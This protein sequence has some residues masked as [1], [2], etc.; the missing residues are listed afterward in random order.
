MINLKVFPISVPTTEEALAIYGKKAKI[1]YQVS[2]ELQDPELTSE[3][4]EK[5]IALSQNLNKKAHQSPAEFINCS[6]YVQDASK[7]VLLL[8]TA[9]DLPYKGMVRSLRFREPGVTKYSGPDYDL[10]DK[11]HALFLDVI[12][13]EYPDMPD[14]DRQTAANQNSR[15]FVNLFSP[16]YSFEYCLDFR[17]LCYFINWLQDF[18]KEDTSGLFMHLAQIEAEQLAAQLKELCPAAD[19]IKDTKGG[20]LDLFKK[21]IPS[22]FYGRS[23][24]HNFKDV[25]WD[26]IAHIVRHRKDWRYWLVFDEL[27][28]SYYVAPIL[29]KYPELLAEYLKDMESLSDAGMFPGASLLTLVSSGNCQ[30]SMWALLER[31]ECGT[32]LL[33][34]QRAYQEFWKVY[35]DSI[36]ISLYPHEFMLLDKYYKVPKGCT[37]LYDCTEPCYWGCGRYNDRLI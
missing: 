14:R 36:D 24:E 2:T 10:Y 8:M 25:S 31:S 20:C 23:F 13:K 21:D 35:H 17:N 11:W 29:H 4:K 27:R 19:I 28:R 5:Y 37:G 15:G 30:S 22:T 16:S 26:C 7:W 3:Q 18:A 1:C 6:V 33:E 9:V 32:V 12:A 34:T